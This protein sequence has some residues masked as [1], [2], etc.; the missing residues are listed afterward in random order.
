MR[1]KLLVTGLALGLFGLGLAGASLWM[2]GMTRQSLQQADA[3]LAAYQPQ[4]YQNPGAQAPTKGPQEV[5]QGLYTYTA[6]EGF[7]LRSNS[8]AWDQEKL[9]LLYEELLQNRHGEEIFS[10]KEIVIHPKESPNALGDIF[11]EEQME[12]FRIHFSAI[13][14]DFSVTLWQNAQVIN[15]YNGDVNTTVESMARTLSHEYG[16]LFTFY[17]IFGEQS[18][19]L[20]TRYA[21]LRDAQGQDLITRNGTGLDYNQNYHRYLI[22]VAAEDYV[23]LMG[24]PASRQVVDFPDVRQQMAGAVYPEDAVYQQG[25][26]AWPQRNMSLPLALEVPG[27][28]DYFYSLIGQT[29]PTPAQPKMEITLTVQKNTA[30]YNLERGYSSFTRYAFSWNT[31]YE[32]ALY[33]LACYDADSHEIVP[34]KTVKPGQ[35]AFAEVG[36]VTSLGQSYLTYQSDGIDVGSKV[37]YV[38]AQLPDGSY[39]LSQRLPYQ[40]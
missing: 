15:L 14:E 28:A 26:N 17:H 18:D 34:V 38:V 11:S 27:L 36:T 20:G 1:R 23:Q 37:F 22:E 9:A 4:Y 10:L 6:P 7:A 8:E 32:G 16:H 19:L 3:F 31:P 35:Q 21:T 39:Y 40:F 12:E 25:A 29:A 2:R 33:T 30:S 24:S 13:P 5:P